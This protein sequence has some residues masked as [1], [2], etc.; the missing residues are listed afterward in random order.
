[1]RSVDKRKQKWF[2]HTLIYTTKKR[3]KYKYDKWYGVKK[4]RVTIRY[5]YC[6]GGHIYHYLLSNYHV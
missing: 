3:E 1:M 6:V 4:K 2:D 5:I